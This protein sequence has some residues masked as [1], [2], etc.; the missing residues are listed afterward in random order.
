VGTRGHGGGRVGRVE[1]QITTYANPG[2]L[3]TYS[4]RIGHHP[5]DDTVVSVGYYYQEGDLVLAGSGLLAGW[6]RRLT[7]A[8]T[9]RFTVSHDDAFDTR[10]SGGLRNRLRRTQ[11]PIPAVV[12]AAQGALSQAADG[13]VRAH[14]FSECDMTGCGLLDLSWIDL[15]ISITQRMPSW[16]QTSLGTRSSPVPAGHPHRSSTGEGVKSWRVA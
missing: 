10:V 2:E 13:V 14:D 9:A 4:A 16:V 11:E 8:L 12:L 6:E 3:D 7:P 5:G 1:Q 15:Q